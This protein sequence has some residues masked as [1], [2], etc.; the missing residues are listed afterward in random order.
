M[1]IAAIPTKYAGVQFRSRLEAR[2]AAFFD[3]LG[4]EWE[5]EPIDLDGYVPDFIVRSPVMKRNENGEDMLHVSNFGESFLVEVKPFPAWP[6]S[7]LGCVSCPPGHGDNSSDPDLRAMMGDAIE[8]IQQSG[9]T[10][11]AVIVGAVLAPARQLKVKR[12]GVAVDT[13]PGE[14]MWFATDTVIA[15]CRH[16]DAYL[17]QPDVDG[18]GVCHCGG[19]L[20]TPIDPTSLWRQAANHAQWKSPVPLERAS[21]PTLSAAAVADFFGRLARDM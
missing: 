6:C 14:G 5:Y 13:I 9:W 19:K 3:L 18:W 8:K 1:K 20:A 17:S 15:K 12:F 2:W 11:N 16:C 21:G 4:W 10:K 7:V